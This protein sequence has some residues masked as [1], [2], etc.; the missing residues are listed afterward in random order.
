MKYLKRV[1]LFC[2]LVILVL[3]SPVG[4]LMERGI[5]AHLAGM[6]RRQ[7]ANR[8]TSLDRGLCRLLYGGIVTLGGL[9]Y[10]EG[11][12]VIDHYLHGGGQDL[13]LASEYIRRSPVVRRQLAAL[14][15]GRTAVVTLRQQEDWRLSYALNPFRLRREAHRVVIYQWMAFDRRPAARTV[16][17]LGL[18]RL[19]VPDGLIHVLHPQPYL[20]RCEWAEEAAPGRAFKLLP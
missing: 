10:P 8:N 2:L 4:R 6:H 9:R 13:H 5:D 3:W 18:L 15:V 16:L 19:T 7:L 1:S 14:P 12:A 20:A 11:A 17:D